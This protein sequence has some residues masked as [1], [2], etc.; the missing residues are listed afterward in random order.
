MKRIKS[1]KA[2]SKNKN[3][4][5]IVF[6]S[7]QWAGATMLRP[8][9]YYESN[10]K[11]IRGKIFTLDD[12]MDNYIAEKGT[13]DYYDT[14]AGFNIPGNVFNKFLMDYD[15]V[16]M[17]SEKEMDLR[18]RLRKWLI[19]DQY[20]LIAFS[21]ADAKDA[22]DHELSHA[23]FYLDEDYRMKQQLIISSIPKKTIKQFNKVL[24]TMLYT[25]DVY[26]DEMV[27]FCAT[28]D[29]EYLYRKFGEQTMDSLAKSITELQSNFKE[30]K[31]ANK[32]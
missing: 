19:D 7:R 3:I 27:A 11:N 9:E 4:V 29:S 28:E 12:Y 10:Y 25:P 18:D 24:S 31:K 17:L 1:I 13:F 8:Q 15:A 6:G 23:M 14:I 20:Y 5:L 32:I 22:Y 26:V 2:L 30:A 21:E 16:N